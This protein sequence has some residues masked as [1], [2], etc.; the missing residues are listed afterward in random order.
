MF[1]RALLGGDRKNASHLR[2]QWIEGR[3]FRRRHR[4]TKASS[5]LH[6]ALIMRQREGKIGSAIKADWR[7][8]GEY[9]FANLIALARPGVAVPSG[10][11]V[12]IQ[13]VFHRRIRSLKISLRLT[14]N[15][16]FSFVAIA[17]FDGEL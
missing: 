9:N 17:R 15:Y 4:Q 10:F 3:F 14:E 7:F 8:R 11:G 16:F 12:A 13:N 2:R 1:F 6:A 5:D